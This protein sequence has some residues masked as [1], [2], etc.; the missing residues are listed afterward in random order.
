MER[1]TLARR[2]DDMEA[3]TAAQRVKIDA[4]EVG[5]VGHCLTCDCSWSR[6]PRATCPAAELCPPLSVPTRI[7]P[8]TRAWGFG[9][10]ARFGAF[11]ER[12]EAEICLEVP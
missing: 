3:R 5:A 1:C 2:I 12:L 6:V 4:H 9:G 11:S 8:E 10:Q 7:A